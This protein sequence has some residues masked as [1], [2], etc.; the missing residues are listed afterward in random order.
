MTTQKIEKERWTDYF[1]HL[2]NV[3]DPY[4]VTVEVIGLS[5]GDQIATENAEFKGISYDDE[6]DVVTVMAGD[7]GHMIKQPVEVYV[8]EDDAGLK[9]MEIGDTEGNKHI[10]LFSAVS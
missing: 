3:T 5:L 10:L 7:L 8:L 9:S 2:S 1:D 6:D 4:T